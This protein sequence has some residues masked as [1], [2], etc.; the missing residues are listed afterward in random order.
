LKEFELVNLKAGESK[1]IRF[2][3]TKKMLEFYSAQN[4]WE[5]EAGKFNVFIGSD[6]NTTRKAEFI[7]K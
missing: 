7:L 2:T 3:I 4:I 5:A 6:S 1:K